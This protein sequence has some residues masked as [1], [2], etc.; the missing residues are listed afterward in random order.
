VRPAGVLG[1]TVDYVQEFEAMMNGL[2]A[3]DFTN[4]QFESMVAHLWGPRPDK[5]DPS[6]VR[7]L[8]NWDRRLEALVGERNAEHNEFGRDTALGAWNAV[9]SFE[10]YVDPVR[11]AGLTA[12]EKQVRR[13]QRVILG[14]TDKRVEKALAYLTR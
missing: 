13:S 4:G 14:E 6:T 10:N 9:T 3:T 11:V 7:A 2:L 1:L 5:D 8:G 12:A